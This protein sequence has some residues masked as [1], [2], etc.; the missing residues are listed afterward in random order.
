MKIHALST[1]TVCIKRTMRYGRGPGPL[2]QVNTFLGREFTES[3]PIHVW[4]IEHPAGV[5]VVDTGELV[6]A[7]ALPFARFEIAP[8]DEIGPQLRGLGI[9]P[10]D[11][12]MVVLTHLH[13]DH[14][15]G[16]GH[17]AGRDILVNEGEYR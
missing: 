7:P 17:F 12:R 13:G 8:E 14:I 1:G 10:A 3:L 4:V 6:G 5:I 15:D 11:V 9:A 2:R 16:V